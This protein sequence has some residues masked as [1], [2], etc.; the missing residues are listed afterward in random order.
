MRI[1]SKQPFPTT[2]LLTVVKLAKAGKQVNLAGGTS[3]RHSEDLTCPLPSGSRFVPA[4]YTRCELLT[5]SGS[6][7]FNLGSKLIDGAFAPRYSSSGV[8]S[9]LG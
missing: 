1:L 8:F 5:L 9:S 4:S 2:D 7:A 6:L 3:V